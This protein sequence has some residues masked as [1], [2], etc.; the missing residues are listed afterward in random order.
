[1]GHSEYKEGKSIKPSGKSLSD[2]LSWC[3]ATLDRQDET[4]AAE[5]FVE[6]LKMDFFSDM[7]YVFTPKGDVIELPPGSIPLDFAYRIHTEIGHK[8][9]GS[10]INGKIAPLDHTLRN[11]DIVEVI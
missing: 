1:A 11:G 5:E 10:R 8:T 2:K 7:V 6:S 3:R 9:V 4:H